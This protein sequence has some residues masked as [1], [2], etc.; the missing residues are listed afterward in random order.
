MCHPSRSTF[1]AMLGVLFV[2]TIG[3]APTAAHAEQRIALVVG[4][5][6]YPAGAINSAAN[7][8]GLIAQTLEAAGFEVTGAR[9]LDQDALRGALRDFLDK[10]GR[11]GSD[12]VAL[13]YL[14]G[15]GLQLEGE[16]YFVPL[17]ARIERAADVPV[18][19]IR[20]SDYTRALGALKL[21]A[22]IVVLDLARNHP[23]ALEGEPLAGGLALVQPEPGMLIAFNAA[24]GTIAPA[25]EGAY[26]P[27]AKALAEMMR[28]GGLPPDEL[29][30][31]VRLRV[32]D[33]TQ[34]AQVPWDAS[35]AVGSFMFFERT[36]EAPPLVAASESSVALRS[37]AIRDLG[38][39]EAYITALDR[40]ALPDYLEF[41][42]SYGDLPL[43]S[44]IWA[45]VAARREAL[46]WRR[47][48]LLDTPA[49]Y[50]SYLRIY[51]QGP[52]VG[53]CERRLVYLHAALEPPPDFDVVAYDIPPPVPQENTFIEQSAVFFGDPN[54]DFAPP[55][56]IPEDFLPPP[57]PAL[58]ELPP[59]EVPETPFVLPTPVYIP[60]PVWVRPPPQ[61]RAPAANNVK[62]AQA[63]A[64][65]RQQQA[66]QAA[67]AA[68][69]QQAAQAAAAARQQQQAAQAAA[70]ARQQQ[71]A[72]Q[73]AAAARQ[74]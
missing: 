70:A 3:I 17:D 62:A 19:A 69:Q 50:W 53:D 46:I 55:P 65:A 12:D 37:R 1:L 71:Q 9:D 58:D 7:D 6:S 42:D 34:G 8:A 25:A 63:A 36:A 32:S 51:S 35:N 57:S 52:H 47:T 22:S 27:Y 24:P 21:K 5:A 73:A 4:N 38:A 20:L 29:F 59:P 45:I 43:A 48:R 49:A 18:Q 33:V 10:A 54:Y 44:R 41:L 11:L 2:L 13:V 67:A 26:S 61:L 74:Q 56:P 16:N 23:F 40:D 31:R 60:V 30:D 72:A 14:C 15:Y 66:A 39:Q 68:R 28:E 64:A